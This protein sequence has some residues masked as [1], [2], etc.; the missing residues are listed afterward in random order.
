MYCTQCGKEITVG[1]KFCTECGY[2]VSDQSPELKSHTS[3]LMPEARWWQ[4]LLR[5]IY[6]FWN[7][8]ILWIVP[9]TWEINSSTYNYATDMRES[10]YGE[11]F[12]TTLLVFVIFILVT[13]LIKIALLY[14]TMGIMPQWKREFRRLF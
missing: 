10:S 2:V 3:Q 7:L 5:V 8:Q 4:R 6:I 13:R 14:I 11:A 12:W 9:V 1:E